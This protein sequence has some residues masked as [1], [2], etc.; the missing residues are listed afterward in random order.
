MLDRKFVVENVELVKKNCVNRGVQAD[1]DQVVSLETSRKAKLQEA[2]EFNRQANEINKSIGKASAEDRPKIVAEGKRLR[3]L[4]DAASTE[5]DSLE[6]QIVDILRI[7]PNLTHPDAPIGED[8]K[9][10]L[11]LR[12]GATEARKFDFPVLDHVELGEKLD[13]IDF[14]AGAQVAGAGFYYLKNEAVLLELALQQYVLSLLMKEGFVPTITPDM[15]RTEILHGVGFIPR[16]P[17]TQIYSIENTDLNLVATAE[18]TLGGMYAGKVL[19]AEQLPQL[20]CGISHCYRTEAGAAGRASRGLYR[21]HQ[22]TKVEMFAFTLPEDSEA[23]LNKFCELECKIFDGLK[24]PYRVVD[25]AT[26]DLGGPAY[27]KFDLEAWMP[28]RGEAGEW[29]EVTSTSNCTDYQARRLNIRYKVKGEKGTHFAHTLNGTAIALSRGLIA[30]LENYQQADGT[31]EVPE[32][33]RP[34]MGIDKIGP[35]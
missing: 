33:L 28:G 26:G 3:E 13:L 12:R 21:V 7:I 5:V 25:T 20:F 22:F 19:E 4:K 35:R 18:I 8:D 24:I 9:A 30:V 34:F 1:V 15:A 29:G 32:V 2:E 17:E 10:N 6:A 27:R 23:T 11:E 31:I 14:E 16:G